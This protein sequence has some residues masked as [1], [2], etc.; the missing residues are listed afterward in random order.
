MSGHR[1]PSVPSKPLLDRIRWLLAIEHQ[2]ALV[3][4]HFLT[5]HQLALR[6]AEEIRREGQGIHRVSST[7]CSSN[8]SSA[9][10]SNDGWRICLPFGNS[11]VR[12]EHGQ[13][14]GRRCET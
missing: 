2:L 13:A 9:I 10:L 14:F 7:T 8:T 5:F 1:L 4:V 3:N 12:S 11:D 6:L